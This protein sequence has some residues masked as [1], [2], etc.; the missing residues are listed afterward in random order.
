MKRYVRLID[1]STT[2]NRY[3]VTPLFADAAAFRELV[4][5]LVSPFRGERIDR[6]VC[7][8]AL[9]FI[10]GTA[11]AMRIGVGVVPI[12]KGG[13]LPV[14]ADRAEFRDYTGEVKQLEMR[15]DALPAGARV[16]LVDEWIETGAQIRAAAKLIEGREA[17]VAGIA[18]INMDRNDGTAGIAERYRVVSACDGSTEFGVDDGA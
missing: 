5:D 10:L 11:V 7:V 14:D 13:K 2:G 3:D 8:D 6:V 1:T 15:K 12:R 18:T 9:G 17:T 4:R 16:L